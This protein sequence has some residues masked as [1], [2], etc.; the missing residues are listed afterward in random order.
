MNQLSLIISININKLSYIVV[1]HFAK[2]KNSKSSKVEKISK[3]E[4]NSNWEKF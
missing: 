4:K 2:M 1:K 3:G